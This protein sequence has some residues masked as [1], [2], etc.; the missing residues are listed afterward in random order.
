MK[1]VVSSK[2]GEFVKCQLES[3]DF[4]HVHESEF[5]EAVEIGDLILIKITKI[6]E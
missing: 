1:A 3:G 4:M 6:K 5:K 2:K